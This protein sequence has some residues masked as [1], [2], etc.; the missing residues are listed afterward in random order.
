MKTRFLALIILSFSAAAFVAHSYYW[1]A[2]CIRVEKTV[3]IC[4]ISTNGGIMDYSLEEL[5]QG[6][7]DRF[8]IDSI[9]YEH[10]HEARSGV[11]TIYAKWQR[12][13]ADYMWTD[14]ICSIE[15]HYHYRGYLDTWGY[16]DSMRI[17]IESRQYLSKEE[18]LANLAGKLNEEL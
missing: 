15:P 5:F 1:G 2:P 8:R 4:P 13:G 9:S 12:I 16:M 11:R 18:R 10:G 7:K 6:Y 17:S 14:C 3:Y